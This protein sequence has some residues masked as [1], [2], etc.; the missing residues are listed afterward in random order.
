MTSPTSLLALDSP[1]TSHPLQNLQAAPLIPEFRSR[2]PRLKSS[3]PPRPSQALPCPI[4]CLKSNS[5]VWRSRPSE[6][7]PSASPPSLL[8]ATRHAPRPHQVH[9]RSLKRLCSLTLC[10]LPECFPPLIYPQNTIAGVL[11]SRRLPWFSPTQ[12]DVNTVLSDTSPTFLY[13]CWATRI[14]KTGVKSLI[15]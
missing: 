3:H 9:S 6:I 10:L 15:L 4:M 13:L 1:L 7:R 5:L 2:F 8:A 12:A 11:S 14:Q